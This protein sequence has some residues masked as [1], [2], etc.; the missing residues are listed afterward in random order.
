MTQ[1]IEKTG[2]VERR[3]NLKQGLWLEA[4][5]IGWNVI[6]GLVAIVAGIMANSVALVSFGIDSFVE[7]TSAG[8]LF[9]RLKGE[10]QSD[11]LT[12]AEEVE[13]K[14]GRIAGG[15]LLLLAAYIVIDAGRR[16]F[17]FGTPAQESGPGM[18][19]TAIS[20]VVMPLLAWRKLKV[21]KDLNSRALRADAYET[22][23][24]IWLSVSTFSGLALNAWLGWWW[25][26]PVAALL[27]VPIVVCEGLEGWLGEKCDHCDG[28]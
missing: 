14:A 16:L 24:C 18:V 8:V 9:W 21:A 3:R 22:I 2:Q 28:D 17:G 13:R 20:F 4:F 5:T 11:D 1:S 26:D 23:A 12:N 15:L 19:L 10:L 27:F 25:A 6:E 7:T